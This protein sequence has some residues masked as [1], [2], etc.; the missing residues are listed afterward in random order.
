M[1]TDDGNPNYRKWGFTIYRTSYS[2]DENWAKL[3]EK[4][5]HETY[6][7]FRKSSDVSE[8]NPSFQKLWSLFHLDARS[9]PAS[10]AG[11]DFLDLRNLYNDTAPPDRPMNG[12]DSWRRVFLVADDII[13]GDPD[14]QTVKCVD[15]T[16]DAYQLSGNGRCPPHYFGWMPMTLR[17]L[18]EL[19]GELE[20][21]EMFRI[22]PATR[23]ESQ[24]R[25]WDQGEDIPWY[26]GRH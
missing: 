26:G 3:L 7:A 20:I 9:D 21:F 2:S 11:L 22:A 15:A 24:I 1:A 6:Q 13:L 14:L 16:H 12:D 23:R 4:I 10:L 8:D 17:S 25:A 5:E 19:W 18:P